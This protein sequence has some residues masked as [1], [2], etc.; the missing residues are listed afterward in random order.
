MHQVSWEATSD[1]YV[2][3]V[4]QDLQRL[5]YD[6]QN[7]ISVCSQ[8]SA[9]IDAAPSMWNTME[10]IIMVLY[11]QCSAG[12]DGSSGTSIAMEDM[13][14]T[15]FLQ[16]SAGFHGTSSASN[17]LESTITS[18]CLWCLYR[19]WRHLECLKYDAQLN[20]IVI[21]EMVRRFRCHLGCLKSDG[22][23]AG[24]DGTTSASN[25]MNKLII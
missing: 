10:N 6:E 24:I 21:I 16:C 8:Y 23:H 1:P 15:C 20:N 18:L 14:T 9:V 12:G 11:L 13:I 17:T 2:Y 22:E 4:L 5:G 7:I 3:N 19:Y 25:A